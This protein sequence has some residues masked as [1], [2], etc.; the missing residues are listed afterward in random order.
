VRMNVL[1]IDVGGS[2]VKILATGHKTVRKIASG[3]KFTARQMVAGVRVLA[4]GWKFDVIALGFPGAVAHNQP[5]AEPPNLG[6]GWVDFD[7]A[8]AFGC[9]VRI[10]ND[11]AMQAL[12]AYEGGRMLFLGFGTGL[13]TTLIVDG[14]IVAMELGHLSYKKATFEAYVGDA[15]LKRYGKQKWRENVDDIVARLTAALLPEYIVLGGGNARHITKQLPP[16]CRRGNN[17]DAF[18]GGFRLWDVAGLKHG[19]APRTARR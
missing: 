1:V 3:R 16:L 10:I 18:S 4:R 17:A 7:Y 15:A 11:A 13:G 9:P 2:S 6:K 8:A 19:K 14:T 5:I 12:G